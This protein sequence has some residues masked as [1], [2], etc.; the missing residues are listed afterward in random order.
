MAFEQ[1]ENTGVLFI[2]KDKKSDKHPTLKGTINVEG[3][4]FEI[5]AWERESKNGVIYHSL[6]VSEPFVKIENEKVV[7]YSEKP[8]IPPM[9][10]EILGV[11]TVDDLPF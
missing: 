5:A 7:N 9:N 10:V 8:P 3:K 11:E 4:T 2:N 1:N 6:K